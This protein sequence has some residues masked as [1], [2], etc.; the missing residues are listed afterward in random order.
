[1]LQAAATTALRKDAGRLLPFG[2]RLADIHQISLQMPLG[3]T[4]HTGLNR[5]TRQCP[6]DKHSGFHPAAHA[7]ALMAQPCDQDLDG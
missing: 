6:R 7:L 3:T 1:M 2:T 5:F 4:A